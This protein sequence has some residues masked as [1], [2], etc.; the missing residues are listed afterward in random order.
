M[1]N[2]AFEN[3]LGMFCFLTF[4][5]NVRISDAESDV[6]TPYDRNRTS[7]M[8]LINVCSALVVIRQS[9]KFSLLPAVF[10]YCLLFVIE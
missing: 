4:K 9:F 5:G 10:D 2:V 8:N 7:L 6:L 3:F 1:S